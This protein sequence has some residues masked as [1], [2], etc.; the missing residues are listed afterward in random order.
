MK[1]GNKSLLFIIHPDRDFRKSYLYKNLGKEYLI[2]LHK[3]FFKEH[4][5]IDFREIKSLTEDSVFFDTHH[6]NKR[7]SILLT[8]IFSDSLRNSTPFKSVFKY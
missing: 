8:K 6:L 2:N 7:G 1:F 5:L 4:Q 3:T